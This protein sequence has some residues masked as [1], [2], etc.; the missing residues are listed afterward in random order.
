MVRISESQH[1]PSIPPFMGGSL[2]QPIPLQGV[3]QG[4]ITIYRVSVAHLFFH[5]WADS[6]SYLGNIQ[7]FRIQGVSRL[8][9]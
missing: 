1:I 4:L 3:T 9:K 6:N 5:L 7:G 2:T 8:C